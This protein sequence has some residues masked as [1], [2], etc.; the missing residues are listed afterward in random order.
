MTNN[1]NTTTNTKIA[2]Y[3]KNRIR[4]VETIDGTT[5]E[6]TVN[7]RAVNLRASDFSDRAEF[8]GYK[9]R[10]AKLAAAVHAYDNAK[11]NDE[12]AT[13]KKIAISA[14]QA[15]YDY[16]KTVAKIDGLTAQEVDIKYIKRLQANRKLNKTEKVIEVNQKSLSAFMGL[17]E[18]CSYFR[19]NG[20]KFPTF[21]Q[22]KTVVAEIEKAKAEQAKTEE[23]AKIEKVSKTTIKAE[24]KP[25]KKSA[26]AVA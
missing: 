3:L 16:F 24:S 1:T 9:T 7:L 26:Q 13:T 8:K 10:A 19:L 25:S 4:E 2:N 5:K 15:I 6:R 18:D 21:N 20:L 23:K 22:S 14:L 11:T 12:K 17:V